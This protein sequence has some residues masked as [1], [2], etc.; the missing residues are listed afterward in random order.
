MFLSLLYFIKVVVKMNNFVIFAPPGGGKSTI[1][2]YLAKKYGYAIFDCD[3]YLDGIFTKELR[4]KIKD[5]KRYLD[6]KKRTL[7]DKINTIELSTTIIDLG[8]GTVFREP[9]FINFLKTKQLT[10]VYLDINYSIIEGTLE[11]NYK[12]I[13]KRKFLVNYNLKDWRSTLKKYYNEYQ[14]LKLYA[15]Y[16]IKPDEYYTI[17]NIVEEIEKI[18][19]KHNTENI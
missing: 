9:D 7:I 3:K 14:T 19:N 10:I 1:N 6:L 17:E 16:L 18:I 13:Q 4:Q 5:E 11:R 15:D 12:E 2:N 8:G